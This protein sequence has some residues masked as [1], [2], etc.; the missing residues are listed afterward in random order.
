MLAEAIL[1]FA[2][3]APPAFPQSP[4]YDAVSIKRSSPDNRMSVTAF[5]PGRLMAR[6][7]T[8][9]DLIEWAYQFSPAQVAGGAPWMDSTRFDIEAKAEG[10]FNKDELLR[11]LQPVLRDRF[12]LALHRETREMSA[13][14][15]TLGSNPSQR[16][17]AQGGRPTT[18]KVDSAPSANA[19]GTTLIFTG[20][21]VSMHYLVDYLTGHFERLV[22]DQTGLKNGFDFEIQ[23][24]L[25]E[26]G[27]MADKRETLSAAWMQ[28]L[29]QLG[30][31]L[32]SKRTPVEV[33][34]IDH[35]EP[36]SAN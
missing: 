6:G 19:T 23:V 16:R 12:Q 9:K 5:D 7:V 25:D 31:K 1:L 11:M 4:E 21:S 22:V 10:S 32:E 33:L 20:Q 30:F 28:V 35:A 29:P 3:C 13:Y 8:L 27:T 17:D 18:I 36:P 14:V 24:P 26:D 15:L 34:V 2:A